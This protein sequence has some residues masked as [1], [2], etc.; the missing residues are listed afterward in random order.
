[1]VA[2]ETP[3]SANVA[4]FDH[5]DR[6]TVMISMTV[7]TICLAIKRLKA[8][9]MGFRGNEEVLPGRMPDCRAIIRKFGRSKEV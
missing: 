5:V 6:E 3:S 8:D 2:P 7:V 9:T 4:A 1:M